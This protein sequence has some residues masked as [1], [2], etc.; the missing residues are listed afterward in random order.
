MSY[1]MNVTVSWFMPL[2]QTAWFSHHRFPTLSKG[3]VFWNLALLAFLAWCPLGIELGYNGMGLSGNGV[4][5]N[6]H[7]SYE[8][9]ACLRV[10][11][12]YRTPIPYCQSMS[13]SY[14]ISVDI[15]TSLGFPLTPP[16]DL[17][18]PL[19]IFETQPR[20]AYAISIGLEGDGEGNESFTEAQYTE[21]LR[22]I[23]DLKQRCSGWFDTHPWHTKYTGQT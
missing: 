1:L 7:V 9:V 20:H 16:S 6:H 14:L 21:L 23:V 2:M 17:L 22:L 4:P 18:K 5:E 10:C 8:K 12:H 3:S 19:S 15:P 13:V 11:G